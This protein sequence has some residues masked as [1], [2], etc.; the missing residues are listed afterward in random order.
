MAS[1]ALTGPPAPT[2][3]AFPTDS[4]VPTGIQP[5]ARLGVL[6]ATYDPEGGSAAVAGAI[7]RSL[8]ELGHEVHVLTGFPNYPHGKIYPGYR[9]R[10]YQYELRSGVHVHR[11]PLFPSHD[12]S[13]ARRAATYL[14]FA[15]SA[16]LRWRLL[17]RV[18]G[19]LVITS[20]ATTA[21]P[22]MVARALFRRPYV[23]HIQDLWPQTVVHSGF[24]R[25]HRT[26]DVITRC[27]HALC[28]TSYRWASAVAVT[29]PGMAAAL[30]ARGVSHDKLAVIPNW[31]DEATFR[32]VPPDPAL[33]RRL[34]LAGFVVMYA[35][36]L[37]DVQGLDTLVEAAALV[38]DLP[39]VRI[40]LAGT[41]VAE[42]RL[43]RLAGD[44]GNVVFLGQQPVNRMADLAALS[45]VQLVSLA[46]RPLFASTV[47]S[48]VQ[49]A[50]A[51]GRPII[52]AIGGDAARL[53]ERSG[54]GSAVPP[55]DPVALAGA[56]RR[57]RGLD[58]GARAAM[59]R[60]GR[61][62]YL[63]RLSS[64]IGGSALST[65]VRH[66]VGSTHHG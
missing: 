13:A 8:A 2:T 35:G 66:A 17:S 34:G 5:A 14:S 4:V 59:G 24:V 7:C 44:A 27:L 18:D 26:L 19:W 9:L 29:A 58:D 20:Q 65:L 11:V 28:D 62:F 54:A 63:E 61:Q 45:D 30:H 21:I 36:S 22:A 51:S 10:P 12:R 64:R 37:G 1:S 3:S 47:P 38:R 25:G 16:S 52:G 32:P 33:A 42:T 53:I 31:I 15:A 6:T 40:V 56:I 39:D 49:V 43:R 50:L 60:A 41:G 23:L 48:K 57:M 46:D 55:G